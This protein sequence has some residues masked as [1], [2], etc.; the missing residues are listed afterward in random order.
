MVHH[1]QNA[2]NEKFACPQEREKHA[3]KAQREWLA[4]FGRTIEQEF[5]IDAM[6]ILVRS[7][8]GF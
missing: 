3:Y 6:T 4:L 8:C 1:L 5:E 7:N 2:A